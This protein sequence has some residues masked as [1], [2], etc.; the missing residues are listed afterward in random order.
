MLFRITL[1]LFT[2][3]QMIHSTGHLSENI[4]DTKVLTEENIEEIFSILFKNIK[5]EK[6]E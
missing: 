4:F 3:N 2:F 5:D 6:A 1:L